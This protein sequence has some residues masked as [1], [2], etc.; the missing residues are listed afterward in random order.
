MWRSGGVV[1]GG[2]GGEVEVPD[3]RVRR[4]GAGTSSRQGCPSAGACMGWGRRACRFPRRGRPD[5]CSR[6]PGCGCCTLACI[7]RRQKPRNHAEKQCRWWPRSCSYVRRPPS[8]HMGARPPHTMI[9]GKL[10]DSNK[11][12]PL[13]RRGPGLP[14]A[15]P[16]TTAPARPT[17][18]PHPLPRSVVLHIPPRDR[19]D[20]ARP[21][22]RRGAHD[23]LGSEG[24]MAHLGAGGEQQIGDSATDLEP[25]ADRSRAGSGPISTRSA[26]D[27]EPEVDRFRCGVR[28]ISAYEVSVLVTSR[29]RLFP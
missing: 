17:C 12:R 28:P 3:A 2:L 15:T 1:L 26:T 13:P 6:V 11:I 20:S 5:R 25:E 18:S 22:R 24:H 4:G 19:S 8:S 16:R 7:P 10:R 9:A 21:T 29:H 23:E 14:C 27:L